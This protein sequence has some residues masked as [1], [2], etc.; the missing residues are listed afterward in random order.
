MWGGVECERQ[1]EDVEG[2]EC[3]RQGEDVGV[4]WSVRGRGRMLRWS[5][6]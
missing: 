4:A 2:V 5:G 6:V 1:R 3:E